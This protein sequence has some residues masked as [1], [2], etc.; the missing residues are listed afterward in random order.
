VDGLEHVVPAGYVIGFVFVGPRLRFR[1]SDFLYLAWPVLWLAY[2]MVR[3]AATHPQ[4]RGFGEEASRYPYRFL[5]IDR[6]S[7]AEVV[8][9]II[10]VAALLVGCGFAYLYAERWLESGAQCWTRVHLPT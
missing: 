1:G 7:T 10:L 4:F 6:V 8:G 2:T 3:G 9:S 5:D